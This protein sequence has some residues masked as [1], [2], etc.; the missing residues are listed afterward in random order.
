MKENLKQKDP[1]NIYI[2]RN[3]Y[4][5]KHEA[6]ITKVAKQKLV[7]VQTLSFLTF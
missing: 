7:A 3:T 2:R 6:E 1:K 4:P 5:K